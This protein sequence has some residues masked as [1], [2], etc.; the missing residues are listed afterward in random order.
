[1]PTAMDSARKRD[2]DPQHK[3]A[4]YKK[5]YPRK[6]FLSYE[7]KLTTISPELNSAII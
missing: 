4:N 1:M 2:W 7:S 5:L 3:V 6:D